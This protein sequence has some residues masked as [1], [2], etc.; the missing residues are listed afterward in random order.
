M[1][2]GCLCAQLMGGEMDLCQEC[3]GH[4]WLF[5]RLAPEELGVLADRAMR[6]V[7]DP[8][9]IVFQ[10]GDP[11]DKMFLIKGGR[12]RLD[13][14]TED[15]SDIFLDIRKAGDF[16]GEYMLSEQ[17]SAFP[18]TA[19]CMEKTLICGFTRDTFDS[20]V[21]E[22]PNIGLEVIKRMSE[23]VASLTDRV[24]SM[25]KVN[26]EDRLYSVL[27]AVAKEHGRESDDGYIIQFPLTHEDLG[28]L[29]GAHRVSITRAM[30][31][32]K[33]S[34]RIVKQGSTML[35]PFS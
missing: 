12:V 3:I 5:E 4:L 14:F 18:V 11:A 1:S 8:G 16:I 15:G 30:K 27:S 31:G 6:K 23:Q 9:N 7:Y 19:T 33:E 35:L 29:V 25:S 24:G 22:Y 32:L 17:E 2:S 21:R 10:Q 28:F 20:L 13:K 26:L 34:G